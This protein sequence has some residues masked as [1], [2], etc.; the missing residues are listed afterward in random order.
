MSLILE[1]PWMN[2]EVLQRLSQKEGIA[3]V[4]SLSLLAAYANSDGEISIG[5]ATRILTATPEMDRARAASILAQFVVAGW[6]TQ[7]EETLTFIGYGS[8]VMPDYAKHKAN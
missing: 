8:S 2:F 4:G 7:K 5:K 3:L 1:F 6:A